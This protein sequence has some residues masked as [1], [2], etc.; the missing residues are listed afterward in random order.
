MRHVTVSCLVLLCCF[1]FA[2]GVVAGEAQYNVGI[3]I[4]KDKSLAETL[5]QR[6]TKG[7]SFEELAKINSIGPNA[8]RGGRLGMVPASKLRPEYR[9]ALVSMSHGQ[10]SRVIPVEEGY[11]LLTLFPAESSSP[12]ASPAAPAQP[13]AAGRPAA[14]P[15]QPQPDTLNTGDRMRFMVE[16]TTSESVNVNLLTELL[17][18][19]EFMQ[20]SDLKRAETSFR[21]AIAIDPRDDSSQILLGMVQESLAGK[22]HPKVMVAV[23]DAFTLMLQGEAVKSYEAF[24]AAGQQNPTL[25]Q[26]K[27]MAGT[28]L[29]QMQQY[30]QAMALLNEVVKINPQYARTY[31]VI[32]NIYYMQLK[33]QDAEA[34]YVKALNLDPTLADGHY[35]LGRLYMG[36][37]E[38]E[39]AE[40]EYK[41]AIEQDPS[42]YDA[43]NDLG[44]I[45]MYANRYTEADEYFHRALKVNPG[46]VPALVNLGILYANQ[47]EWDKAQNYLEL[48]VDMPVIMPA[49]N[50]NLGLVY[51]QQGKW[52]KAREQIDLAAGAGHPVPEA[53]LK[54]LEER[55]IK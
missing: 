35:F 29:L 28:L 1:V 51:M 41:R 24:L 21:N 26:A 40:Q 4:V 11:T 23:A 5:R 39:F 45:Y 55:R 53:V 13:Q 3:L 2:A 30:E 38:V 22:Y 36:Y 54:M 19:L 8:R 15:G 25:W 52:E 27:L 46:M 44:T 10:V 37:G 14:L 6:I 12:V 20:K 48:A 32:G 34:A 42:L 49:A 31:L 17:N 33:G 7:E 9:Q 18:G 16:P 50:F 47:G 43:Y